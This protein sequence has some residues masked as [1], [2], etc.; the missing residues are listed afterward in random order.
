MWR[1]HIYCLLFEV[2]PELNRELNAMRHV[3]PLCTKDLEI[4]RT[5]R[6]RTSYHQVFTLAAQPLALCTH[7]LV[8]YSCPCVLL[9][10]QKTVVFLSC[11]QYLEQ[12]MGFEPTKF[13]LEGRCTGPLCDFCIIDS[14]MSGLFQIYGNNVMASTCVRLRRNPI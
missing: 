5:Q 8:N 11:S 12:K 10:P 4:S 13:C 9:L 1:F 2:P 3:L 6:T 7:R 14:P